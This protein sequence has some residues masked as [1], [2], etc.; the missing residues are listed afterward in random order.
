M[1]N[2]STNTPVAQEKNL[3]AARFVRGEH[4]TERNATWRPPEEIAKRRDI[5]EAYRMSAGHDA[6]ALTNDDATRAL[7]GFSAALADES[8]GHVDRAHIALERYGAPDEVAAAALR[9]RLSRI[10]GDA[11]GVSNALEGLFEVTTDS[12]RAL[13]GLQ[14][15]LMAWKKGVAPSEVLSQI[16]QATAGV[17]ESMGGFA[18]VAATRLAVDVLL[19][20]GRFEQALQSL[21]AALEHPR[22]SRTEKSAIAAVYAVWAS[23][24]G[25]REKAVELLARQSQKGLLHEDVE[26]TLLHLLYELDRGAEAFDV[27][28]RSTM[29]RQRPE[30]AAALASHVQALDAEASWETLRRAMRDFPEDEALVEFAVQT[31]IEMN[32][33]EDELIDLLNRRLE[34]T[35][36]DA[37][38]VWTLCH[39][40]RVYEARTGMETAAAEVYRE[41]LGIAPGHATATRALGR[42]FSRLGEWQALGSLYEQEIAGEKNTPGVWRRHFQAAEVFEHRVGNDRQAIKHYRA[43]L[44]M[45]PGFLPALK[46][47]ARI[48][49]RHEE[50]AALADLFLSSVSAAS[51]RRQKLYLLDKVADVAESHLQNLDVAIGAWEEI[52]HLEP[53]HP[54]AFAALGR[55]Y[56]KAERWPSLV[57]LNERELQLIDEAEEAAAMWVRNAEI[58]NAKLG[59][60]VLAERSYRA[61]LLLVPDFIPALEGLGR[62]LVGGDRFSELIAM[63]DRQIEATLDDAEKW[64]RL[65]AVAE[66][67]ETRPGHEVEAV[68]LYERMHAARPHDGHVS[69]T[70]AVLY[71]RSGQ[72][73]NLCALNARLSER[74]DSA[75]RARLRAEEGFVFEWK[76]EDSAAAFENYVLS[77]EEAPEQVHVVEGLMRTWSASGVDPAVLADDLEDLAGRTTDIACRSAYNLLI[78]RLRERSDKSAE[79]SLTFRLHGDADVFENQAVIRLARACSGQRRTLSD[80]RSTRPLSAGEQIMDAELTAPDAQVRKALIEVLSDM[81]TNERQWALASLPSEHIRG[82]VAAEDNEWEHVRAEFGRVLEGDEHYVDATSPSE[83]RLRAIEARLAGDLEASIEFTERELAVLRNRE[84]GILRCVELAKATHDRAWLSRATDMAFPADGSP[85]NDGAVFERLRH[86]LEES[87]QW[88]R[89]R[90]ALE[91]H[92]E[93]STHSVQRRAEL[94]EELGLLLEREFDDLD[95][96]ASAYQHS[97]N[98]V[99]SRGIQA[100]LVRVHEGRG[101]IDSACDAQVRHHELT[102]DSDVSVEE[103][104]VSG[105]HLADLLARSG[106]G[107]ES[108]RLLE[109]LLHPAVETPSYRTVQRVLAHMHADHGDLARAASLLEALIDRKPTLEDAPD[110]RRLVRLKH[111]DFGDLAAAYG[112]QWKL[113]R[114]LPGCVEDVED[115]F[116]LAFD[117]NEL[118]ECCT[119]LVAFARELREEPIRWTLIGRAAEAFDED[120]HWADEAARLYRELIEVTVGE[121]QL[122]FRR[123]LSFCLS[124]SAGREAEAIKHF[125]ALAKAEPFELSNYQGLADLYERMQAY[126]RARLSRQ[127]LRAL[128]VNV[129]NDDIRI[130][131]VPSRPLES[132]DVQALLVPEML[133]HGVWDV[134]S[135]AMPLA[136]KMWPDAL[137]QKKALDG[138]KVRD[139]RVL[140]ILENAFAMFGIKRVR[141]VSSDTGPVVP[142]V[143]D[144]GTVWFNEDVLVNAPEAEVRFLAGFAAA[145]AYSSMSSLVA[146][147]GRNVWHLIEG[148]KYRQTGEGFTDRVDVQSQAFAE[149]VGGAFDTVARRRVQQA[150]EGCDQL[151]DAHCEAWPLELQRFACRAGLVA[152]GEIEAGIAAMLRID[153]WIEPLSED[154]SQRRMQRSREIEE[155][156]RFAF[157]EQYLEVRY[158]LG[159]SGR[160]SQLA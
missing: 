113:V 27:L 103:R 65:G 91:V 56:A 137:P 39:L 37:R 77:L 129:P 108:V 146:F 20:G 78:A 119:Q 88:D 31:L 67:V 61:A 159:L 1:A 143:F 8:L 92:V 72:W 128:R 5:V 125:T 14:S 16:S 96:T 54:T 123:R 52:L 53:E 127:M 160:P 19:E 15:A 40:G 28:A 139:T 89:L 50:W 148:V 13:V 82:F 42:L 12:F 140:Q 132:A 6:A 90:F 57:H 135:A 141:A 93:L 75:E 49:E 46:G 147:D 74:G 106:Q 17:E 59:D 35:L 51:N 7:M 70:L 150:L 158:R 4:V 36:S 121:R 99:D 149:S 102:L 134:L 41:A 80:F 71:R 63:T 115:L 55:L 83:I 98:L 117:M 81:T 154:A 34:T 109:G 73:R 38:R 145:M 157:S 60:A 79:R 130:K 118:G 24:F 64:R 138:E 133:R 76:L 94:F 30:L 69:E 21:E 45:R 112:L 18:V 156:V 131:T 11:V 58:A 114:S 107:E 3:R 122:H 100:A 22:V 153:G 66:L 136:E 105:L 44:N 2:Q 111:E 33:Y 110:W 29:A 151:A 152:C 32:A 10:D 47:A 87:K 48:L 124:R 26:R 68:A 155:L 126:D 97:S 120:L 62:M 104:H 9:L 116:E 142:F 84:I 43:T 95:A 144:D 86:A 23:V 85:M 25:N 101:D